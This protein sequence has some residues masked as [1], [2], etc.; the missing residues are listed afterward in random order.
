MQTNKTSLLLIFLLSM[1]GYSVFAQES[2]SE[3]NELNSMVYSNIVKDNFIKFHRVT[4]EG[5]IS[6]CQLEYQYAYRD[7]YSQ[8][9]AVIVV[10]GSFSQMYT[11]GILGYLSKI[12]PYKWSLKT[13]ELSKVFPAY[14]GI[15]IN[16]FD[17]VNYRKGDF[18]CEDN[19]KC[20]AYV[21]KDGEISQAI[22]KNSEIEVKFSLVK[23]GMDNEFKI[24][25]LSK[26]IDSDIS[27][28]HFLNC[29]E[30][31]FERTLKDLNVK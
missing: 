22:I 13:Q 23:G 7:F 5:K 15:F 8:K 1:L 24:F 10:K 12:T 19:G 27:K 16:N 14:V 17:L 31:I 4:K 20:T 9:G 30:E 11:K 25:S 21:D 2:D 29:M 6:S 18:L 28:K 26:K 3:V